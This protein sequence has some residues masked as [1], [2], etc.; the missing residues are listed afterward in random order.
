MRRRD[1][2]ER[3]CPGQ[4]DCGEC[5]LD[6]ANAPDTRDVIE[7]FRI[8]HPF[9]PCRGSEFELV[10]K[11]SI[12]GRRRVYY[13]DPDGRLRTLPIEWTSLSS[14][15]NIFNEVSAGR[16]LFSPED[17]LRLAN[18]LDQLCETPPTA[19]GDA[20]WQGI[21]EDPDPV[22]QLRHNR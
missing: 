3:C 7:S 20:L 8:E 15:E 2:N 17:L 21:L 4:T 13:H 10:V 19:Y 1:R 22:S 18:H 12:F 14:V 5:S 9:H 11:R 6:K 16:A